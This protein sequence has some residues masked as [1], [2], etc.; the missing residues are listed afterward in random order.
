MLAGDPYSGDYGTGF[1]G[2]AVNTATYVAHD[3]ALG[4]LCFGGAL[5]ESRGKIDITPLD[6]ARSR[7]YIAPAGVWITLDAG[8]IRRVEFDPHAGAIRLTLDPANEFTPAARLRLEQPARI[9]GAGHFQLTEP[10]QIEPLRQE[11]GAW[12][13]PLGTQ[14]VEVVLKATPAPTGQSHE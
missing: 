7:V 14:P 1:W 9:A 6:A 10:H 11:R 2:F 4:W 5:E 3:P 13:V 12:I 8:R